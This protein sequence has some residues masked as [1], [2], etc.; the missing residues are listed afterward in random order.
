MLFRS[1]SAGSLLARLEARAREND[2]QFDLFAGDATAGHGGAQEE[3]ADVPD[4]ATDPVHA[5]ATALRDRVLAL[6]P[7]ALSPREA[8]EQ[9]YALR[10][11]L[12]NR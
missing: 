1:R 7:D 8:L 10:A 4:P 11:L 6:N 12:G 3:G 2:Q 5:E 9:I